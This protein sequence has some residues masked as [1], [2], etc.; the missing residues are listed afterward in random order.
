MKV[1]SK[2][3]GRMKRAF[4]PM[5]AR[6][7][8]SGVSNSELRRKVSQ[9]VLG[10]VLALSGLPCSSDWTVVPDP[11]DFNARS[12]VLMDFHSGA[13]I[14]EKN[15][16][17]VVDPAS[18]TKL[19][20]AYLVYEALARGDISLDDEVEVSESAWKTEGSR[21]FIEVGSKVKLNDLLMG[22]VVQS[23]NDASVALAEHVAGS[24][25]VFV[26]LMNRK[27][28]D[29]GMMS[30]NFSNATGLPGPEHKMTARDIA[31][32][33]QVLIRDFPEYYAMYSV[34]EFSYNNIKQPN[35]NRLL[36]RD[37]NVDGLK[38]GHTKAAGY[39][40]AASATRGD[41][42][43]ISV[44]LGSKNGQARLIQ[45]EELLDHG[46]RFF[47]TQRLY[48][49]MQPIHDVRVWGGEKKFLQIGVREDF[50]V[51]YP[52]G[53]GNKIE[54]ESRLVGEVD[55]PVMKMQPLGTIEVS[56]TGF[57]RQE[58]LLALSD[59]SR[60]A[61]LSRIYDWILKLF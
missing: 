57:N 55:A 46:F 24:E 7:S 22:M 36:W 33:S 38:T 39:C 21:T 27:A 58:P 56:Y 15:A 45:T 31:L 25:Q 19:M 43:L 52:R 53:T 50:Y 59:V 60:G 61:F 49:A 9:T 41:M 54:V 26:G 40:L 23:G 10:I 35:R 37:G 11:P 12:Y 13:V 4:L 1:D 29:L 51:T 16:D 14:A 42:R 6:G 47:S 32:L 44:V 34:K 8:D 18:I 17:V 48:Q 28:A 20:T 2:N 5:S 3:P 30:S